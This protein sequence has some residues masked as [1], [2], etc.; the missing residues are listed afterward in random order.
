M[1]NE[2]V[3]VAPAG[4]K[5]PPEAPQEVASCPVC[6]GAAFSPLY[7]AG[8]A[9]IATCGGC[10]LLLQ[11]PQPSDR[12]LADIYGPRYFIGSDGDP[13]LARQFDI[14]KQAT[15]RLQLSRLETYIA[16]Q[17][18]RP[19]GLRL[20]EIGCGHGN[21]LFEA[22]S[23]GYRVHG[24]EFSADAA[25][26][27]NRKLGSDAVRVGT[28]SIVE[29]PEKSFDVCIMADVIE[30]VRDPRRFLGEVGRML[31]RGATIYIATP[32]VG[33]VTARL[34]R[35]YWMEF[36]LEHLFYF[37]P[38]TMTRLLRDSG[39]VDIDIGRG[40]KVLTAEY[41]FGHFDKYPM[42]PLNTVI[43]AVRACVPGKWL[44]RERRIAVSGMDVFARQRA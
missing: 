21:L 40:D 34:L 9:P 30:H 29:F 3:E 13:T 35:R 28:T 8:N 19:N 42:P 37:T 26:T 2:A 16:K 5:A 17:G 11:N 41:I 10:G 25:R 23:R 4:R 12:Q 39:F 1:A 27:A 18:R 7:K 24:I 44:Q 20:L 6:A 33:S 22:Q 38:G 15:A 36:K 32:N 31:D 43:R 14:V